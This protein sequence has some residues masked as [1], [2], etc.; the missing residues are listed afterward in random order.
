MD[1]GGGGRGWGDGGQGI[2]QFQKNGMNYCFLAN[3]LN[4]YANNIYSLT[5]TIQFL[6]K[7]NLIIKH[8]SFLTRRSLSNVYTLTVLSN[9]HEARC[10]PLQFQPTE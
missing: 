3:T 9:E 10:R 2:S 5:Y 1:K 6:C 8:F 7:L 4:Y